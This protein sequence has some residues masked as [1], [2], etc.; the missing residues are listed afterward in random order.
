MS[1]SVAKMQGKEVNNLYPIRKKQK[2]SLS[3]DLSFSLTHSVSLTHP[4][5]LSFSLYISLP[6]SVYFSPCRSLSCPV[7]L[8]FSFCVRPSLSHYVFSSLSLSFLLDIYK[9]N[10]LV[11]H[12][13]ETNLNFDIKNSMIKC[14][15]SA[16]IA[17]SSVVNLHP[18]SYQ[19]SPFLTGLLLSQYGIFN[20]Q[21]WW[22]E[23]E[24]GSNLY[25]LDYISKTH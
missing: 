11:A 8:S 13:Y 4:I 17:L 23:Q 22:E 18:G 20:K 2:Y 25:L 24:K 15:E 10:V 12:R 1:D 21:G 6:L 14:L 7:F 3:L 5:A 9:L 19:F 16:K